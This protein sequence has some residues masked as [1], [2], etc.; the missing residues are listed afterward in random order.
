MALKDRPSDQGRTHQ[1]PVKIIPR[2]AED[3]FDTSRKAKEWLDPIGMSQLQ[4]AVLKNQDYAIIHGI[5]YNMTFG[6]MFF[7]GER[8]CVMLKRADGD[9]VPFGYVSLDKILAFDFENSRE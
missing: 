5:K 7:R 4:D 1:P 8:E 2:K 6:H 3:I 9:F